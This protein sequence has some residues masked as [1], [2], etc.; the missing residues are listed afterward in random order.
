MSAQQYVDNETLNVDPV[1][2]ICLLYSKAIEKLNQA[3]TSFKAEEFDKAN[4]AV[5][6]AMEIVVELQG[7]LSEKGGDIAANLADL[8]GYIQQ[9]LADTLTRGD[10]EPLEEVIRLLTT[11]HQGWSEIRKSNRLP[12][13]ASLTEKEVAASV[14]HTWTL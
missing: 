13:L 1:E 14:G 10:S 8:Y 5:A 6:F 7:A 3:T 4:G 12:P 11:L 2:L 9:R